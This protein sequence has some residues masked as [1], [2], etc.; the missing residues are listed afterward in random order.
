MDGL[1]AG[2]QGM[3]LAHEYSVAELG[4]TRD[5]GAWDK[6]F[7]FARSRGSTGHGPGAGTTIVGPGAGTSVP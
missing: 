7:G 4:I 1:V 5:H 2:A 3:G 6:A